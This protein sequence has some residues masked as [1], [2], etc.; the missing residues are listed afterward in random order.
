[1]ITSLILSSCTRLPTE[2]VKLPVTDHLFMIAVKQERILELWGRNDNR[3][4]FR[5]LRVYPVLGQSGSLGP[6]RKQ[7]DRQV[8][9]GWYHVDRFN[10]KSRFYLSL[11]LNYPNKSD[12]IL[13]DKVDPGSD[14]FIHG[15]NVSIGC[16]A[17]GD[18]AIK[19]IYWTA[20]K[21][22]PPV[23]VLI[24]PKREIG[25]E[26]TKLDVQLNNI[27][28]LFMKKRQLPSVEIDSEGNY[29]VR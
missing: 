5:K 4:Q 20:K 23:H 15:S 29:S 13:G 28:Q 24:I 16:L 7:G 8:P 25:K 26:P 3:S 10:P 11:G 17:M 27:Y 14:I 2:P 12:R 22:K 21:A 19:D 1:M 6:K 9:E 18:S